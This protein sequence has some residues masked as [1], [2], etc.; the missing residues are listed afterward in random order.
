MNKVELLT[1]SLLFLLGAGCAER[2]AFEIEGEYIDYP[3]LGTGK[4]IA[5]SQGHY[6]NYYIDIDAQEAYLLP[7]PKNN[8]NN[9]NKKMI[10]KERSIS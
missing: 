7:L 10:P 1:I 6:K 5:T 8:D 4:I 9:P 2:F 3:A